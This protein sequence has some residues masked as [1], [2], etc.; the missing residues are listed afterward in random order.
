M[1]KEKTLFQF[2]RNL[3]CLLKEQGKERTKETYQS[4]LNSFKR[5]TR[6]SDVALN[7]IN[8]DLILKYEAY[9]KQKGLNKNSS[10]FYLRIL[11]ATYNR[12]VE[13]GLILQQNPFKHV[14]TGIDETTKRAITIKHIRKIKNL[15]LTPHSDIDFARDIFMFSFYTRGMSFIDIAYLEK[16]NLKNG[17][18]SY[19]R[20]KTGK[21]LHIKWENCMQDIV[22][23]HSIK[24]SLYLLN[25]LKE[26]DLNKRNRYK[27]TLTKINYNLKL[28]AQKIGVPLPITMYVAR[29]SWASIA[30][31]MQIPLSI[32]SESMGHNSETTT[33]VYLTTLDNS[34]IDQANKKILKE[35]ISLS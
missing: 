23:K 13:Q 1:K 2:M 11:R 32:I 28:I 12:A 22:D 19:R 8:C 6:E 24:D 27:N 7:H 4:T 35:L 33:L 9:L 5:F 15:E 3:I 10:S 25:I 18:L 34:A 16:K 21:T 30:H 31:N 14:Y 20:R 29:H 26:S 17:V